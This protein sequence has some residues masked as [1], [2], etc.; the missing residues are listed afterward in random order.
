MTTSIGSALRRLFAAALATGLG[1]G[2]APAGAQSIETSY[3]YNAKAVCSLLATF[4]DGSLAQGTYRTLINVANPTDETVEFAVLPVVAGSLGQPSGGIGGVVARRAELAGGAALSIDCGSIA[5]FF[6]PTAEGICFD[7]AAIDG[8]VRINAPIELD[9]VGIY[10][11]RPADGEV[12]TMD[13][14]TVEG[15]AIS[16]TVDVADQEGGGPT[17]QPRMQIRNPLEAE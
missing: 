15:R 9:V 3:Q 2:F 11:A 16:K 13:I 4:G 12:A 1:L 5:G 8:F 14:E 7:F 17:L 6:C 10:T